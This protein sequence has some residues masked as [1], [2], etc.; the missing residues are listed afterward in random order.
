VTK[1]ANK[2]ITWRVR[3]RDDEHT[4]KELDALVKDGW[5]IVHLSTTGVIWQDGEAGIWATTL[6]QR[7]EEGS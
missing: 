3:E 6:L 1:V 2:I 7:E 4:G 5:R